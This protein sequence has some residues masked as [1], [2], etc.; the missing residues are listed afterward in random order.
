MRC[1]GARTGEKCA[2]FFPL[3]L[4][5]VGF[6]GEKRARKMIYDNRNGC[7]A[8]DRVFLFRKFVR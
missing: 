7:D 3:L 6:P 1:R 5:C 4:F 2:A 8:M